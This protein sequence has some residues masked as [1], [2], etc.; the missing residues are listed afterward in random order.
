MVKSRAIIAAARERARAQCERRTALPGLYNRQNLGSRGTPVRLSKLSVFAALLLFNLLPAH[1]GP[2]YQTT[3]REM[4]PVDAPAVRRQPDDTDDPHAYLRA[5]LERDAH[6]KWN[7]ERQAALKRDAD[8]LL[9]LANELKQQVD[10]SNENILS[11]DVIK[12]AET[13]EKL[14]KSVREKMKADSY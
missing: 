9:D 11:L 8:K 3:P 4:P 1:A 6:K 7:K 2:A 12:K 14:A 13:I 5:Q 10:K